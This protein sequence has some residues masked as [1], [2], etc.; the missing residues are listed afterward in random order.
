MDMMK[1]MKV[2]AE[3]PIWAF[4]TFITSITFITRASAGFSLHSP[5][6]S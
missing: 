6:K 2:D 5:P 3:S 4:I 1:V